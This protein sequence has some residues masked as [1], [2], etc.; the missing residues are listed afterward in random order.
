MSET[1]HGDTRGIELTIKFLLWSISMAAG[2]SCFQWENRI[3]HEKS[4][5][6]GAHG[7]TL[8]VKGR[9]ACGLFR[10]SRLR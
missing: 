7:L 2:S 4:R 3:G 10:A 8:G 5:S 9:A 1:Q 6:L